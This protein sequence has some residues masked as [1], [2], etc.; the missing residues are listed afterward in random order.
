MAGCE[1]G[2]VAPDRGVS[3]ALSFVAAGFLL[4][5]AWFWILPALLDPDHRIRLVQYPLFNADAGL[6]LRQMLS[7]SQTWIVARQTPYIGN[8]LYPPLAAVVF[9]PFL[10]LDFAAAYGAMIF[11][12]LTNYIFMTFAIPLMIIRRQSSFIVPL[13]LLASGLFSYGLHFE[14]ARGQFDVVAVSLCMF[15]IYLYHYKPGLR[16]LAYALFTLSVQLKLYPAIFTVM[17]ISQWKNWRSNLVRCTSLLLLNFALFFVLGYRIFLDFI[18]AIERQIADPYSWVGNHSIRSFAEFIHKKSGFPGY[19]KELGI[20]IHPELLRQ[21]S[22]I[23]QDVLF[24]F[25]IGCLIMTALTAIKL[26]TAGLNP[27]L[28]MSCTVAALLIPAVSHDYKLSVLAGPMAIALQE[29]SVSRDSARSG[30]TLHLLIF[31]IS[32]A[33]SS[34]LVS[35]GDRP[36]P[37]QNS[38]PALMIVLAGNTMMAVMNSSKPHR[39]PATEALP[40][41]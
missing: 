20:N 2:K 10:I 17:F 28:L 27:Y 31:I 23:V 34:T 13:L 7:Y 9:V 18:A 11:F 3:S 36:V 16:Y 33:Y 8:N 1:T 38:L 41:A 37:I 25:V 19:F 35:F 5:Y 30:F 14:L 12:T 40:S 24:A 6:D 32:F 21:Y 29:Y 26:Q 15:A 22:W 39:G 4:S